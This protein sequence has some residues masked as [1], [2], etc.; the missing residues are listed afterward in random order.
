MTALDEAGALA[1]LQ[2]V[3]NLTPEAFESALK[4]EL[5]KP[6]LT[7]FNALARGLHPE[8]TDDAIARKVHLMLLAYLMARP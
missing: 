6:M 8:D 5:G 4:D 2:R 3:Q 7:V 1:A